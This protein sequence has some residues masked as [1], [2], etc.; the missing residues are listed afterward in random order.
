M[1]TRYPAQITIPPVSRPVRGQV[2][3]PGSKSITNRAL[4]I[5]GLAEGVSTLEGALF[6]DDTRYLSQALLQLGCEVH[7]EEEHEQIVVRGVGGPFPATTADLYLGNAGTATRFLVGVLPLGRGRF[8]VDGSPRM[9]ER[10]IGP[11]LA[12]LQQLGVRAWA[13]AGNDCPPVVIEA[14]GLR[15]GEVTMRGDVSSQYFSALML[16]APLTE[17]GIALTVSG[18]LV[19]APF[20]ELTRAV[21]AA[22]GANASWEGERRI[23]VPGRQG[24]RGRRFLVEPDATAASYFFAAAAVTGGEVQVLGLTEH[25]AQGD[26]RFVDVLAQMGCTVERRAEGVCVRGPACLHGIE[27]DL[28][29]ISDTALTL[30]AVA[31]FADS[32]VR[33]RGIAHSRAQETDRVAAMATELR[34][35]G[36]P[37]VEHGDGWTIF[38]A[39]PHGGEVETYDDHRLAM[40]F[41]VL[42]LR[43]PGVVIRDPG[44]VA[45][46]F[47]DFFDRLGR[48]LAG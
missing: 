41:A 6:S 9:R 25:S 43:T 45:K 31:P 40:S 24:Y 16:A 2:R 14:A 18:P 15:G 44:C 19:S 47:P 26:L 10:P 46:T 35:L 30:A 33:V 1:T 23:V 42:S 27:V 20:L 36:V 5:A 3:L 4:L 22:F 39:T 48:L 8:R 37:V 28:S 34:K 13:E 21:M 32:P 12:G 11:L 17:E 7:A 38:P 29:A